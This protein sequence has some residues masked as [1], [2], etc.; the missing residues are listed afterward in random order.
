MFCAQQQRVGR[1]SIRCQKDFTPSPR[2]GHRGSPAEA[3]LPEARS[4]NRGF[5]PESCDVRSGCGMRV[6]LSA[7]QTKMWQ[8]GGKVARRR[9]GSGVCGAGQ[10]GDACA[11]RCVSGC[12]VGAS[13]DCR[14]TRL[15]DAAFVLAGWLCWLTTAGHVRPVDP[16]PGCPAEPGRAEPSRAG[17]QKSCTPLLG[18]AVRL[19]LLFRAG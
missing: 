7:A 17:L 2:G 5:E 1:V 12:V 11:W 18:P 6:S 9:F 10:R 14:Q 19:Q 15:R 16:K 3:A 8:S 13:G 4:C